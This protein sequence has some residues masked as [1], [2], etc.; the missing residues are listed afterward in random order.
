MAPMARALDLNALLLFYEVVN[1]G[2]INKA[3]AR[4]GRPKSTISR[5]LSYL[6]DQVGATLVRK[7]AGGL[8]LTELGRQIYDHCERIAGEIADAGVGAIRSQT[9]LGGTLRVSMPVDFGTAWISSAIAAFALRYPEIHLIVD[10]NS[11]WIDVAEEPYDV[12]IQFGPVRDA[13]VAA[14]PIARIARGIYASPTFLASHGSPSS[15]DELIR[16]DCIVTETQRAEGVWT[17]P[18]SQGERVAIAGRVSVNSIAVARELVIGGVGLGI[19]PNIMCRNDVKAN[20]LVRVL[21]GETSP[22]LQVAAT[23]LGRRRQSR[24]LRAFLDFMAIELSAET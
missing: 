24:R 9:E 19:L 6:E 2:S 22:A 8:Q 12:A 23:F 14:Q 5:K 7:G 21:P 4:S 17:V 10:T 11:R 18:N 13:E 1:A 3:A 15:L 20:R 16:F